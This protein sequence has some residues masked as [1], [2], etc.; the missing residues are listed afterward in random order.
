V[1]R[2]Y[3][4]DLV[5][6]HAG[7]FG[8]FVRCKDQS[9]INVKKA[10]RQGE[11]VDL[12]RVDDFDRE[13][14]LG[15]G[16]ANQVLPN[17]VDVFVDDRVLHHA[18][19]LFHHHGVLLAHLDFGFGGVPV[20]QTALPYPAVA[21]GVDVVFAAVVDSLRRSICVGGRAAIALCGRGVGILVG[22]AC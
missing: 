22:L 8:L 11:S 3:V 13:R 4:R 10:S 17:P 16:V 12:V 2:R 5:G 15:V 20:A 19:G 18:G 21:N 7:Q 6:H 9:A 1:T 14:H